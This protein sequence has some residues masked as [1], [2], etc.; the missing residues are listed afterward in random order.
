M[1][2]GVSRVK[3]LKARTGSPSLDGVSTEHPDRYLGVGVALTRVGVRIART[4]SERLEPLGLTASHAALLRVL[5]HFHQATQQE[6]ARQLGFSAYRISELVGSL[7]SAG[8][9]ELGRPEHPNEVEL[10]EKGRKLYNSVVECAMVYEREILADLTDEEARTLQS[11][12]RRVETTIGLENRE[13][14]VTM[15]TIAATLALT[16]RLTADE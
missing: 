13:G 14:N 11:L 4:F 7:S 12:V 2:P 3:R 10:T 9:V 6:L 1:E 5:G 15:E 16:P 8:I